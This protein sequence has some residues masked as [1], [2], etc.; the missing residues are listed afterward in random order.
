MKPV[1]VI[2]TFALLVMSCKERVVEKSTNEVPTELV[3]DQ[4]SYAVPSEARV[5]H[6]SWKAKVDMDQ[7]VISATATW[8][9]SA[10]P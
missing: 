10:Q 3:R 6:L 1:C 4:H 8:S 5:S 2:F 7:K 9:I